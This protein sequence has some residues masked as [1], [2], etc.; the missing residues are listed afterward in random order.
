MAHCVRRLA[1]SHLGS[2]VRG[3]VHRSP[4]QL[5]QAG[6]LR[7]EAEPQTHQ[8]ISETARDRCR[9]ITTGSMDPL[10]IAA[11]VAGLATGCVKIVATLYTW[12]D[13]T[14]AVDDNVASLCE[15]IKALTRVLESISSASTSV[16]RPV[17]AE[18][19]PDGSLWAVVEATLGDINNTLAK[20]S[21]LLQEVQKSS[22]VFIRGFLKKP[23]K[24]IKFGL[25]SK[26]IAT[27]KDR[28][29]SYNT[30]LASTLQMINV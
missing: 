9:L 23:T 4:G 15:E 11:S 17:M 19:D 22:S 13:D 29:Q 30:A 3:S 10:S 20:L 1:G 8:D 28:V 21:Q 12:I 25:R 26:E 5:G 27:Y 14:I 24:Q 6:K 2:L 18:I 7:A 16:P